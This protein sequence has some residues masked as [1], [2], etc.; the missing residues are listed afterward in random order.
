MG[1]IPPGRPRGEP[2]A[3][4]ADHFIQCPVC[5]TWIDMR[6]LGQVL[7]HEAQGCASQDVTAEH[8]PAN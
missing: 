3:N 6:D 7:E 4:E 2:P 8:K 5:R 1:S